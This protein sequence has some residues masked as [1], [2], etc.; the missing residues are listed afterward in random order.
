MERPLFTSHLPQA[1]QWQMDALADADS[2]SSDEKKRIGVEIVGTA[3]FL[4]QELILLRGKR[5]GEI[6]GFW[7]EIL[8]T[9]EIGLN[10][11]VVGSQIVQQAAEE[12]EV[13]DA[14]FVA[15]GWLPFTEPAKPTKQMRVAAQFRDLVKLWEGSTEVRQKTARGVSVV[16]YRAGPKREGERSD[17]CFKNL[18]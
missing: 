3:Q 17:L 9:N 13:V 6:A 12:K 5:P 7:R 15:Q 18:F 4:L 8:S 2:R 16:V 11:V 14:G 1:I 10:W